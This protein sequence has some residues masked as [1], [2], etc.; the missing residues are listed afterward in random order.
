MTVLASRPGN[1][2]GTVTQS[3]QT[4][5]SYTTSINTALQAITS[6]NPTT[7]T[8]TSTTTSQGVGGGGGGGT[9]SSF[10]KLLEERKK[11]QEEKMKAQEDQL[12]KLRTQQNN[13]AVQNKFARQA[14]LVDLMQQ[15]MTQARRQA[16]QGSRIFM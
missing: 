6:P 14:S 10:Q 16:S 9:M 15:L 3:V 11:L 2:S 8:S 12:Q 5:R 7:S 13:S 4:P 1:N